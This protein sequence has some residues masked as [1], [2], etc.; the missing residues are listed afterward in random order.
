MATRKRST[1]I[2]ELMTPCP[3]SIRPEQSLADAHRLMR[4]HGVRHLPVV[5]EDR[6]FGVVTQGDLRL[7]ESIADVDVDTVHVEEAMVDHPFMVWTETP[8]AEVLEQMIERHIG[9]ALVVDR[10]SL[11]RGRVAGI[12][13][14]VDAMKALEQ[15][16]REGS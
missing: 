1:T 9:S 2:G 7:L 5:G 13:T 14:A 12:F 8:I 15:I 4:A 11:D 10:A 16:T 3:I 6:V